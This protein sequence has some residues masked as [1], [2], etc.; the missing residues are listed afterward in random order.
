MSENEKIIFV[1]VGST[2]FDQII[3]LITSISYL[4]LLKSQGFTKLI[5]QYGKSQKVF[6]DAIETRENHQINDIEIIGFDYKSSLYEEMKKADLIIS[7]AGIC[8][9]N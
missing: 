2:G 4:Q 7:H 6:N 8:N 5:V 1:T 9:S 3:K